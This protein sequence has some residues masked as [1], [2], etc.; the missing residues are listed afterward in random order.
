MNNQASAKKNYP[1][2][3]NGGFTPPAGP[4]RPRVV[5][6]RCGGRFTFDSAVCCD[7]KWSF[8]EDKVDPVTKVA[9]TK[10]TCSHCQ[11]TAVFEGEKLVEYDATAGR[12]I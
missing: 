12:D 11:A 8:P 7:H 5:E 1:P 2:R 10:K 3:R 6:T 4:A 9:S